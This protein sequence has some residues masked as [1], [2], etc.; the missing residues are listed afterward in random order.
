MAPRTTKPLASRAPA[1]SRH[2][3][4]LLAVVVL[5]GV[6]LR[7]AAFSHAAVEHF[8]EGVYASNI[9]FGPPEY[10]YPQQRFFGP[11]LLPALIE[12]GMIAGLP[13]NVAALLP[14]FIAGCATIVALWWFGRSWF[15]A[16]AGLAAAA[17][18]ALSNF[19]ITLTTALTDALLG[20]WL[21]LAID[22]IARSLDRG[23]YRWAIS[24]GIYTGLAWWTKYNGWLP[25][26]IGGAA[27]PVL[28]IVVRPPQ[29]VL[30]G[31]LGCFAVTVLVAA[32]VWTPYYL[33]L[34]SQGGY[35]PIAANHAKYFVGFAGW[36]DAARRQFAALVTLESPLDK[37]SFVAAMSVAALVSRAGSRRWGPI[38]FSV[39]IALGA[40]VF[41]NVVL[42]GVI[43]A[44]CLCGYA[45]GFN[46]SRPNEVAS[47]PVVIAAALLSVWF[48]AMFF[49]TPLYTP[50]VRL[51]LPWFLANCLAAGWAAS[52]IAKFHNL[53]EPFQAAPWR[54]AALLAI[55]AAAG[56]VVA[57]LKPP[58]TRWELEKWEIGSDRTGILRAAHEIEDVLGN[59][60]SRVIYVYGEPAMFFQLRAAGEP[61]VAPVADIP[62]RAAAN[63]GTPTATY[64]I[65]GPH[66]KTDSHFQQQWTDAETDWQLMKS[67]DFNPSPVVWLDLHDPRRPAEAP[68]HHSF[69]LYGWRQK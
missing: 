53:R 45:L 34:E 54:R 22:A 68:S 41:S 24:A 32:V 61:L 15:S 67:F 46:M 33:S 11:P 20:L 59:E 13:P 49:M 52:S 39:L 21:L 43:A 58:R 26:A 30:I 57:I 65:T 17:L 48:A 1:I 50:Y 18:I 37:A 62:S 9:Y 40:V 5:V 29:K 42:L 51:M 63:D 31:W 60:K 6:S 35:G 44:V 3:L 55:I 27:L 4:I 47:N 66:S 16:E 8:D 28:W 2:E 19:H 25:L 69:Q 7:L 12:A 14:G 56:I 38:A 10:A 64:L 23:D 36:L